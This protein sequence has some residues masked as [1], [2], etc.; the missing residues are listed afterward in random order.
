[1]QIFRHLEEVP[2]DFGS[3]VLSVGNF[4]GVHRAHQYVLRE[5]VR[6]AR[7][8]KA[9]AMAVTFEPHPLRVCLFVFDNQDPAHA[10]YTRGSLTKNVLPCPSPSLSAYASPP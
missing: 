6:Q 8:L 7:A 3:T 4:D 2:V 5:V 10:R 9:R 1:M